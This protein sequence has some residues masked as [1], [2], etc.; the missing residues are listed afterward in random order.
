MKLSKFQRV[1]ALFAIL[2]F[3]LII[4]M[5]VVINQGIQNKTSLP[6]NAAGTIPACQ[7][8]NGMFTAR[9]GTELAGRSCPL[10][11]VPTTPRSS[12]RPN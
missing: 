6:T 10:K 2:I 9:C 12:V 8:V 7:C 1:E 4:L 3:S 5:L 11:R